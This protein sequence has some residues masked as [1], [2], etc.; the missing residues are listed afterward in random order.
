MATKQHLDRIIRKIADLNSVYGTCTDIAVLSGLSDNERSGLPVFEDG[1]V[2][3][4]AVAV[5]HGAFVTICGHPMARDGRKML[6]F[7]R[8]VRDAQRIGF[9][10]EC[11]RIE[12]DCRWADTRHIL[13]RLVKGGHEAALKMTKELAAS[14]IEGGCD[15]ESTVKDFA[16]AYATA[17][18]KTAEQ[19]ERL[20]RELFEDHGVP[21]AV[22]LF[23][24][25][26][27]P[28]DTN[29]KELVNAAYMAARDKFKSK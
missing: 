9:S 17:K 7:V 19:L 4:F 3:L 27:P 6:A 14:C 18:N 10:R 2:G 28:V 22:A 20:W 16:R 15:E 29:T 26:W 24:K 5:Q 25:R 21:G 12:D 8:A 23:Q 1:E 13:L 11:A